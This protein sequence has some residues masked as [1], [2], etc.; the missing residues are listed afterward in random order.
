MQKL[1]DFEK[2][3]ALL[4]RY[5]IP[6]ADWKIAKDENSAVRAANKIGFPVAMKISSKKI[7]HKSDI[8]GVKTNIKNEEEAK[9]A[10]NEIM[11]NARKKLH[12]R[13]EGVLVQKMEAGTEVIIGLKK[14]PQ[15]GQTVLFGLGGIFVEIMKD[16]SLRIAPL[17][18]D[19][20]IEMIK[21]LKGYS[22]LA[23]AR[24]KKPANIEAL[25]KVLMAV[26]KIGV[27]NPNIA[28]MDLNPVL[29]NENTAKVVDVR[30]L[31]E[32]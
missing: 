20:C 3:F 17:A 7:L 15:F 25:V 26:S 18:K 12:T 6:Y 2:S 10:F 30:I 27:N 22:I 8:G 9:L 28:E 23:G 11:Q 5:K 4:K 13:P 19:D 16:V 14:D 21:E 31:A 29:V 1:I 32:K 24:G